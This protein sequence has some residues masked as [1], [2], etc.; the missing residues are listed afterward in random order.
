LALALAGFALLSVGDAVI[1]TIAGAWAPTAVAATR[2]VIGVC[3]LAMLVALK[4]GRA[5]FALPHP[6]L[7]L[8]RGGGVALATVGFFSAIFLMPLASATA[9]T[10]TSPMVTA[11]LAAVFLNEPA[12]RQTWLATLVAFGGVLIVLRP[13]FGTLGV[14]AFLP[15]CS[16]FG[17]SLLMIGNRASVGRASPLSL[18][19]FVAVVAAPL[20]VLATVIGA[21]SGI[22][23]LAV[24][25]PDWTVIARC[26]VVAMSASTAHYL[27]YLGTTKAGAASIAPMTYVQLLVATTMGWILFG[28]RPDGITLL[29]AAV[30]IGAG[31]Y[32][33]HSGRMPEPG[34]TD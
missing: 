11:L 30:I 15:V 4:Q 6:G 18:Q 32:L 22:D 17:M 12:R 16:A 21:A 5:G 2:Y 25:V 23:R 28:D 20:L 27:I 33:W 34:M 13:N 19:F 8:L 10:F 26:A 31:L 24:G 29:G 3:A 1:K 14:A 7:Q 9:I